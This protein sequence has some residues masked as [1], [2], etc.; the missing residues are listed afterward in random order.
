MN[1]TTLRA[2]MSLVIGLAV[3]GLSACASPQVTPGPTRRPTAPPTAAGPDTSGPTP[4]AFDGTIAQELPC[5][6]AQATTDEGVPYVAELPDPAIAVGAGGEIENEEF[7]EEAP[8]PLPIDPNAVIP[9]QPP[10]LVE[11]VVPGSQ[12][13]PEPA[14]VVVYR[15]V[16]NT[17]TGGQVAEPNVAV[18]GQSMLMTWN[19]GAARSFDGGATTTYMDPEKELGR[20]DNPNITTDDDDFRVDGGFC[21]DQLAHYVPSHNMWLWVLQGRAVQ[22]EEHKGGN[23]IRVRVAIGD[24]RFDHYLDFKSADSGL[25][26]DVWYDQPKIGTSNGYMTLSIN[27]FYPNEGFAAAVIYRVSLDDMAVGRTTSPDCFSTRIFGPHP[28]RNAADVTYMAGHIDTST[29]IVWRWPDADRQPS[30][31]RVQQFNAAG[32]ALTYPYPTR[33]GGFSD[34]HCPREGFGTTAD[35]CFGADHRMSGAF[36][37]NGEI[38]IVWN[39]GQYI[40]DDPAT[41]W[42]YPS[43][44][45]YMVDETRLSTCLQTG[46]VT[47]NLGIASKNVAYQYAAVAPNANGDLG[48]VALF[49]GG[50]FNPSCRVFVNKAGTNSW[51]AGLD[52]YTSRNPTIVPEWGHYLGIW[53]GPSDSS[54]TAACMTFDGGEYYKDGTLRFV[55]FGR[56]SDQ[57]LQ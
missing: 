5:A 28:V 35:W 19:W 50:K 37:A 51:D 24:G 10:S 3:V 47:R 56:R 20:V 1:R 15:T 17:E 13:N 9:D 31:H 8:P 30:W 6:D 48:M 4:P 36:V 12:D 53:P 29:L 46:C 34:Y 39:V 16:N 23:R 44:Y 45:I 55:T 26:G 18:N 14:D 33:E 7:N 40:T 54:W 21:C 25:S 41:T 57:P 49:G 27:A 32:Q 52:V 2:H 11:D 22:P 38:G 43:V 42:K